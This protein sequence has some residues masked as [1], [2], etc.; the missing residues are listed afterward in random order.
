MGKYILGGSYDGRVVGLGCGDHRCI[1]RCLGRVSLDGL[2]NRVM[3]GTRGMTP[4]EWAVA[5]QQQA[6]AREGILT[7]IIQGTP[8]EEFTVVCT[9]PVTG[10]GIYSTKDTAEKMLSDVEY[11]ILALTPPSQDIA[12]RYP[13]G[14]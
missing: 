2:G 8:D 5:G 1:A 9:S 4:Y 13:E 3:E 10:I 12:R 14:W 6:R 11:A 7:R